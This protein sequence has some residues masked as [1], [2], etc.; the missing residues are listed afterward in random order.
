MISCLFLKIEFHFYKSDF[1]LYQLNPN[2]KEG[3]TEIWRVAAQKVYQ[4]V[5]RCKMSSP[6][7]SDIFTKGNNFHDFLFASVADSPSK[8]GFTLKGENLLQEEQIFS[9]ESKPFLRRETNV[10]ES[11]FP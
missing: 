4:F 10:N 11:Y 6:C 3:K 2:E 5:L 7:F 8:L 9:F 1:F